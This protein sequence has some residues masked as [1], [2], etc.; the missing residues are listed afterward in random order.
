MKKIAITGGIGSGKSTVLEIL[1]GMG[2]PTFSCDGIYGDI[3]KRKDFIDKIQQIFPDAVV[4]NQID[5]K[6]L[7]G[8]IFNNA[9]KRKQLNAIS[10]PIIMKTLLSEMDKVKAKLVFAEVPLLFEGDFQSLFD[11]VIVVMRPRS[12]RVAA[13]SARDGIPQHEAEKRI[14]AQWDYDSNELY[15]SDRICIVDNETDF[16]ALTERLKSIVEQLS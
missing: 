11:A 7:A 14:Q 2:Y 8:I 13:V 15:S 10:H 9:E 16:T 6:A 1:H 12:T 4:Q 3:V 5:K